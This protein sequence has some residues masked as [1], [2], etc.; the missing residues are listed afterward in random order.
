MKSQKMHSFKGTKAKCIPVHYYNQKRTRITTEIL[1]NW[2]YKHSIPEI[3]VFLN[4]I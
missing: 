4:A 3:Q 2:F 1:E